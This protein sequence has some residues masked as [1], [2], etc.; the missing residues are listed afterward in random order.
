VEVVYAQMTNMLEVCRRADNQTTAVEGWLENRFSKK[1]K[2]KKSNRT[3][4]AAG[5]THAISR[6]ATRV[7]RSRQCIFVVLFKNG[8][9][10]YFVRSM[11]H[12]T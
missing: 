8:F 4:S 7:G 1:V 10:K 3:C 11:N 5:A 12:C 9:S 2:H 6:P